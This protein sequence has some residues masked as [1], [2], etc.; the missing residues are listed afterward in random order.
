DVARGAEP[1]GDVERLGLLQVEREASLALVVLV[2]VAAPV[3]VHLE[4]G[5]RGEH[6]RHADAGGGLDADHLG[7]QVREL[8]RAVRASPHPG[9]VGDANAGEGRAGH[10]TPSRASASTSRPSG[11]RTS[12][13]CCPS[14]GA[15]MR[16]SHGVALM[17]YGA[18]GMVTGPA[19]GCARVAKKPRARRWSD[20][21]RS[22]MVETGANGTRRACALA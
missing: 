15:G 18:P 19:S 11:A 21:R 8:Q 16:S 7:A 6:A 1:L 10:A 17:R 22:P 5:E 4:V 12:R 20:A 14:I 13:V 3:R 9:E 2:E